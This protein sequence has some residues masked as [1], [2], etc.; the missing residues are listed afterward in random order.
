MHLR[1]SVLQ[2][3]RSESVEYQSLGCWRDDDDRAIPSLEG[4]DAR[5]DGYYRTRNDPIEKCYQ[6][7]LSRGFAVFA[8]QDGGQCLGSADAQNTYKKHG[9]STACAADGKGGVFANE[10]YLI[11]I[12]ECA[13]DNGGCAQTCTNVQGSYNCSCLQGFVLEA[14]E[15]GC[16]DTDECATDNGGC[17]QTCTN[18]PGSYT[19]SC[20]QGF[21]LIGDSHGCEGINLDECATENGRCDQICT[22]VP[23]SY[24]CFCRRGF[25]LIEDAHGC[26][27]V[28][29]PMDLAVTDIT[30]EGF[31]VTWSPSPDSDLQ[32]Y[33]VVVSNLDTTT[34]VNQ[35]TDEAWFSVVGL[36]PETTYIIRVTA[37]FSSGGWRSQSEA[38]VIPATTAA[39]STTVAPTTIPA[40]TTQQTSRMTTR[41]S[42]KPATSTV[43][44]AHEAGWG[45]ESSD[46]ATTP[47]AAETTKQT[48]GMPTSMSTRP[49][50]PTPQLGSDTDGI[51]ETISSPPGGNRATSADQVNCAVLQLRGF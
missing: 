11:D 24:R 49:S 29:P 26:R 31:K 17:A 47:S 34:A 43:Q 15:H 28:D 4:T 42:T 14:N 16:E 5:L 30:D 50:T 36:S 33:R 38:A 9:P 1:F 41:L 45:E 12:D 48:S 22:N 32:G 8:V 18:V 21:V 27:A 13:T 10:V 46:D 40:A 35:S 7:A 23:G 19:C 3:R 37:L 25:V 51:T 44:H 39:I 20:P 2:T 6:V